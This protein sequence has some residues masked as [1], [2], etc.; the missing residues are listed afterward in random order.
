MTARP[1]AIFAFLACTALSGQRAFDVR[2]Q[3][4]AAQVDPVR[5]RTTVESLASFGT[6]HTLSDSTRTDRGNAAAQRWIVDHVGSLQAIPSS[7]LKRFEERFTA[8]GS[9]RL[10]QP[11]ELVNLGAILPGVDPSR[12]KEVLVIA[13]HYDSLPS[14]PDPNA[15]GPG[16]VDDASGVAVCL[17]M[18]RIMAKEKP[19]IA[20]YF[21]AS[22]A[23]EQGLVGATHLAKRL[24][25]EG[26]TVRGMVA[27]DMLGNVH[28]I[29]KDADST[30]VRCFSEGVPTLE[31]DA[32]K[33]VRETLGGENDGSSREWARYI[34]RFGEPYTDNLDVWLMLRRDRVGRGGDHTPF[35]A[36]GFPAVR[37]TDALEHYD[38]QHQTPKTENGRLYGDTPEFFDEN[39]CAKVTRALL[40][41]F[42]HLGHAPAPPFDVAI[43]G[44]GTADT[45][46]NWKLPADP[47]IKALVL[48]SRRSD[49]IHWQKTK[50]L[51]KSLETTLRNTM[52]DNHV[53]AL[54]TVDADGNESVPVY[55]TALIGGR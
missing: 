6:R 51:P 42:M 30:T 54:A 53:F 31:T 1:L 32:Q 36:Q 8:G 44:M 34:K 55:P 48:Y 28:G 39:Y 5:L 18:A 22:A 27:A 47:R 12:E 46:L 26:F 41:S 11:I 2:V 20:I 13:G 19:A 16:A 10:P 7:R 17:E 3:E 21:V 45:K 25:T 4:L 35:A 37:F 40:A 23:E 52:L 24:K 15:D 14:G 33:R 43:G 49:T 9:G 29:N 50:V 38:R